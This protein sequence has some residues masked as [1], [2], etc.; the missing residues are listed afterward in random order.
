[1][2]ERRLEILGDV[3]LHSESEARLGYM[4]LFLINVHYHSHDTYILFHLHF[5]EIFFFFK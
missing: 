3:W 5:I 1:M 4:K 2:E